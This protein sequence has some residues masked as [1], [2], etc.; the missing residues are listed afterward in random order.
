MGTVPP[1]APE[2]SGWAFAGTAVVAV[3]VLAFDAAS[4]PRLRALAIDAEDAE[5]RAAAL[6]VVAG[7][8]ACV[9]LLRHACRAP[10]A[11]VRMAGARGLSRDPA[12]R[13]L[14]SALVMGDRSL[15]VR[16]AAVGSIRLT[17]NDR[18]LLLGMLEARYPA[19]R[20]GRRELETALVLALVGEPALFTWA[21]PRLERLPLAACDAVTQALAARPHE[22]DRAR[23]LL[24]HP[25]YLVRASAVRALAH[26]EASWMGVSACLDDPSIVTRKAT[27][28]ALASDPRVAARRRELLGD[29]AAEPAVR[30]A[31]MASMQMGEEVFV[32]TLLAHPDEG[33]RGLAASA[34]RRDESSLPERR[35]L[36]RDRSNVTRIQA[37]LSLAGDEEARPLLRALLADRDPYVVKHAILA[38]R[39]DPEAL[40]LLRERIGA[41]LVV[42]R[43]AME[44]LADD[45][46]SLPLLRLRLWPVRRETLGVIARAPIAEADVSSL[47]GQLARPSGQ[48]GDPAQI[49]AAGRIA[50]RSEAIPTFR[51]IVESGAW[52]PDV[53]SIA[54][55][56]LPPGEVDEE[57]VLT[58]L[59]DIDEFPFVRIEALKHL[60]AIP[61]QRAE[62]SRFLRDPTPE[63]RLAALEVLGPDPALRDAIRLLL[64]DAAPEVRV[65]AAR[66][67]R[68]FTPRDAGESL[69]AIVAPQTNDIEAALIALG[70]PSSGVEALP[71]LPPGAALAWIARTLA[72]G[73]DGALVAGAEVE[74]GGA[75][76]DRDRYVIRV[77][78][79][80]HA[81]ATG[82][83]FFAAHALLEAWT[84]ASR[85][86]SR[87]APVFVLVC[88]DVAFADV[89]QPS[90][91]PG[92]LL[93]GPGIYAL[94]LAAP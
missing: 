87:R 13:P 88:A 23:A 36:L 81:L 3:S 22:R 77:P 61:H 49:A 21:L 26:D 64:G 39:G 20:P 83:G 72:T 25:S 75:W 84:V 62:L 86:V 50:G 17:S 48:D 89:P 7:D 63:M 53:V 37:I 28:V 1:A 47:L 54:L 69:A 44:V 40:P 93:V 10:D 59:D 15:R 82:R 43:A 14:V 57:A 35:A 71:G 46:A 51:A 80:E 11:G 33:L 90:V 60:A 67:L 42:A 70:S 55:A 29:E 66:A 38:L 58:L 9:P 34:L 94:R 73:P 85:L 6:E 16:A 24:T 5:I 76:A 52:G 56:S 91:E 18:D 32:R 78:D 65:A 19:D 74:P 45:V 8:P 30:G 27:I 92:G 79:D 41:G 2:V 12:S 31:V 4:R 68:T